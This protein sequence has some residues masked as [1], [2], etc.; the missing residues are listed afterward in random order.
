M[1]DNYDEDYEHESEGNSSNNGVGC[2]VFMIILGVIIYFL[3]K[4]PSNV[5]KYEGLTASEWADEA[6]YW[7]DRYLI[8]RDCVEEFDSF[9]IEEKIK[10]GSVFYYCE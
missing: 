7:E 9:S 6:S 1:S 2:L 3:V 8:F 5:F 4:G 10:Q